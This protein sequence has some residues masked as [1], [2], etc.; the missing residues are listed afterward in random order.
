VT[1]FDTAT[2][3]DVTAGIG[4]F[5]ASYVGPFLEALTSDGFTTV[6]YTYSSLVHNLITNNLFSTIAE[7]LG[8]E[9]SERDLDCASYIVSGGLGMVAPWTPL[10]N[11][12]H[13]LV[14]IPEVPAIQVEFQGRSGEKTFNSDECVLFGSNDTLIAAEL[15]LSVTS[16]GSLHAGKSPPNSLPIITNR[17]RPVSLQRHLLRD[18]HHLLPNPAKLY[19]NPKPPPSHNHPPNLPLKPNHSLPLLPLPTNSPPFHRFLPR[20][21][22]FCPV[23]APRLPP[24]RH[25]GSVLDPRDLLE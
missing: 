21:I 16:N 11:P 18:L 10:G 14:R 13:Q 9:R 7:P 25:P 1:V 17:S 15:C 23:L 20:S 2:V 22:P 12:D 24:L 3:Y 8:C 5:N 6:P 4:P 19:Y